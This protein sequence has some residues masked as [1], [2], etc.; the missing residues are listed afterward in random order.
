MSNS[1]LVSAMALSNLSLQVKDQELANQA[2]KLAAAQEQIE[3]LEADVN[4]K[5]HMLKGISEASRGCSSSV[6]GM[7][8][9]L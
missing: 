8:G 9:L 1:S 5:T 7:Q 6:A 4:K 3:A 2:A